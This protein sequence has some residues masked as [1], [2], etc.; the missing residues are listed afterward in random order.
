MN[1]KHFAWIFVP[2]LAF[3]VAACD[4]EEDTPQTG[5][6]AT[7]ERESAAVDTPSVNVESE[8]RE[9]TTE[10]ENESEQAASNIEEETEEAGAE[11]SEETDEAQAEASEEAEEAETALTD[12]EDED[13][14]NTATYSAQPQGGQQ[15]QSG[16]SEQPRS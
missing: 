8:T 5:S 4:V 11:L 1:K 15:A 6:V 2:A 12:D 10:V 14:T 9:A 7:G 13:D 16:Q 3:G